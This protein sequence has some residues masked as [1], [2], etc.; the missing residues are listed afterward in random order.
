MNK[1]DRSKCREY[2]RV[3]LLEHFLD[4]ADAVTFL[5]NKLTA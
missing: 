2:Q 3:V 1:E 5:H 4:R